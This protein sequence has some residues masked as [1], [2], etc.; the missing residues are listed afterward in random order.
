MNASGNPSFL[1]KKCQ[2][3]YVQQEHCI[4]LIVSPFPILMEA[5]SWNDMFPL[6]EVSSIEILI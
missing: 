2:E 6:T 4:A 3:T 1:F 5:G